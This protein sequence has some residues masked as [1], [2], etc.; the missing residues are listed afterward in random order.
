[1]SYTSSGTLSYTPSVYSS[2][3]GSSNRDTSVPVP[4]VGNRDI[5]E[6]EK[7]PSSKLKHLI[8]QTPTIQIV[9]NT[10][11]SSFPNCE[12]QEIIDNDF[13][14]EINSRTHDAAVMY[15][16]KIS[17]KKQF[18]VQLLH[19]LE[20]ENIAASCDSTATVKIIPTDEFDVNNALISY[21]KAIQLDPNNEYRISP[22]N[23]VCKEGLKLIFKNFGSSVCVKH[24][25]AEKLI[26]RGWGHF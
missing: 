11:L 2:N 9:W 8:S 24:N 6:I 21:E 1:M 5:A 7:K 3:S 13:Y 16:S 10:K 17:G 12:Q 22:D 4:F 15:D 19:L 23:V 26:E 18:A 25:T 14:I 20:S